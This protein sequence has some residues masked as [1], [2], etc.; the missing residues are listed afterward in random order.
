MVAMDA[1]DMGIAASADRPPR[2]WIPWIFG[3]GVFVLALLVGGVLVADWAWRNAEMAALLDRVEESEAVMGE[4][5]AAA[6]AAFEE[7][8]A[9]GDGNKLDRELKQLAAVAEAD[10]AAAGLEVAA[11]PIAVWHADIERARDAYLAHNQAW[12][13]YMDRASTSSAEFIAPQPLVNESFIGAAPF[14]LEAIPW[15]DG[16]A[17]AVRIAEIFAIPDDMYADQ[18]SG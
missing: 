18:V 4:L 2:R 16:Q 14:F 5:Q 10:I 17:F 12:V 9:G 13:E 11:L 8:S 7:H 15:P 6:E 3:A 1:V